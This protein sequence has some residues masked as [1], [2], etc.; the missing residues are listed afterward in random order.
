M[1]DDDVALSIVIPTFNTAAMT[2]ATCR[3]ARSAATRAT[4]I[5]VVD[6]A[7]TDN[8]QELLA[9]EL[10]DVR[11]VR[12]ETNSR[13]AAA[14]NAGVAA[15]RGA[16]ILLLNSDARP[17]REALAAFF[18]AFDLDATLGIAGA[19]LLNADGTPQWSGGRIPTM[20][21]LTVLAGGFAQFLPRRARSSNG[22]KAEWVS[23]AA[24]M[25]RRDVWNA[26]GPLHEEYEFYAQDLDFC[27][28][29]RRAGWAVRIVEEA[30]VTHDGGATV[31]EWRGVGDLAHD[32]GLLW[33]DLLTWAKSYY[34]KEWATSARALMAGAAVLRLA[35]RRLRSVTLRGE[36]RA[37]YESAT[38]VYAGAIVQLVV[39]RKQSA[40]KRRG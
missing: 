1:S 36:A 9:S 26:A 7:S 21:W 19:Q 31:R 15:S 8:T 23:G 30:R 18:D 11:V 32:P 25:F 22:A 6:D 17:E 35:G 27:V 13:F 33:L 2:L 20:A 24:M 5:I 28:R 16:L 34:G 37:T 40:R 10:P 29:A 12:L 14:A 38:A 4:E 3:A 39:K